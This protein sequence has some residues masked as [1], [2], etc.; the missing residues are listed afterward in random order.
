MHPTPTIFRDL[1]NIAPHTITDRINTLWREST[2][3]DQRWH[4]E[5][6]AREI[7]QVVDV[8]LQDPRFVVDTRRYPDIAEW[9]GRML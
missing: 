2:T 9:A 3:D 1:A 4:L 7:E 6:L 5:Q 8:C